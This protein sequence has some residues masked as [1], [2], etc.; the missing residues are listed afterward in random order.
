[1]PLA[2]TAKESG[3]AVLAFRNPF[4]EKDA[5]QALYP[6]CDLTKSRR[7]LKSGIYPVVI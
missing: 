7:L 1:M 2:L 6:M 3:T 5:D 4:V